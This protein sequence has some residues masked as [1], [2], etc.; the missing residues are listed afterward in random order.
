MKKPIL[1]K[2]ELIQNFKSKENKNLLLEI[3]NDDKSYTS[4]NEVKKDFNVKTADE[5]YNI[6]LKMYNDNAV[7]M[8]IAF[9]NNYNIQMNKFKKNSIE[10]RNKIIQ[11]VIK[12]NQAIQANI[13]NKRRQRENKKYSVHITANVNVFYKNNKNYVEIIEE[14][15]DFYCSA[16]ELPDKI[17]DYANT[18]FNWEE[19]SNNGSI[20]NYSYQIINSIS[21]VNAMDVPMGDAGKQGFHSVTT[22]T[23]TYQKR[24]IAL[25]IIIYTLKN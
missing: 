9:K 18:H 20:L 1:F 10:K 12:K 16:Y 19:S 8:N 3:G 17:A 5:A 2:I 4:I 23:E 25:S 6:L 15:E 13:E 24:L 7:K 21:N 11:N 22:T 14:D